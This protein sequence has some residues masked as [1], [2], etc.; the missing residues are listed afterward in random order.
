VQGLVGEVPKTAWLMGYPLLERIFY[1]LVAGY[2]VWGNTAHQLET[3]LFMDYLRMEG[4]ANLLMLL[5]PSSRV[6]M[7]DAW[8]RGVDEEVKSR[9]AGGPYGYTGASG[10]PYSSRDP[11]RNWLELQELLQPRLAPVLSRRHDLSREPDAALRQGLQQLA[12]VRGAALRWWPEAVLLR[13]DVPGAPSRY[14]SVLRNTGHLH[15]ATLLRESAALVPEEHTLSVAR[16]F[17]GSY[18]NALM[19][20]TPAELP[21]LVARVAALASEAD[22]RSLADRHVFRRSSSQFWAASDDLLDAYMRSDPAEAGLLD[23][24]RLEN[25]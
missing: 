8:Y 12:A 23:Y 19:H 16:G 2:D 11:Q 24:G 4:E 13:V 7:R 18:P 15:V 3:R 6:P 14:F 9:V 25:R 1:L 22:Y 17:I 10:V 20:V 5:P 21:A